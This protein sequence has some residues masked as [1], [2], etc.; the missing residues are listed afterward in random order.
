VCR[1][2]RSITDIILEKSFQGGPCGFDAVDEGLFGEFV[3][4]FCHRLI[5]GLFLGG[6]LGVLGRKIEMDRVVVFGMGPGRHVVFAGL[7]HAFVDERDEVMDA[8]LVEAITGELEGLGCE[9]NVSGRRDR[10]IGEVG[11]IGEPNGDEFLQL[12][13]HAVARGH[14]PTRRQKS[15]KAVVDECFAFLR[16]VDQD[17]NAFIIRS[18]VLDFAERLLIGMPMTSRE[19]RIVRVADI[20]FDV[21]RKVPQKS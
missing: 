15:V 18:D 20:D 13:S 1:S 5:D 6:K 14:F 3:H 9:A 10:F 17:P 8:L 7:P 11:G 2:I 4:F 21:A 19:L 16:P 12:E